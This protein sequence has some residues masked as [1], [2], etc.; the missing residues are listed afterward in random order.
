MTLPYDIKSS[1]EKSFGSISLKFI[2]SGYFSALFLQ[3]LEIPYS[4]KFCRQSQSPYV[5]L[6]F[7]IILIISAYA[8]PI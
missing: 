4:S 3:E 8:L 7:S 1:S 6:Y 2:R 5:R